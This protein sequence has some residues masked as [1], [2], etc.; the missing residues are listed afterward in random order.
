MKNTHKKLVGFRLNQRFSLNHGFTLVEV[1]VAMAL[2]V[3]IGTAFL[4]SLGTASKALLL[5]DIKQTA[6][7]IAEMQMEDIKSQGWRLAY[8][9]VTDDPDVAAQYPG[10]DVYITADEFPRPGDTN[11]QKII[12]TVR[13]DGQDVYSVVSYKEKQRV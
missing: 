13:H 7:N 5:T 11:L 12:V 10:F 3:I 9:A 6:R 8:P 4:S 2:L 1:L